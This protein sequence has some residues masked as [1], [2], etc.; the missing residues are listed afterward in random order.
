MDESTIT[1]PT[2][3]GIELQVYRF[4][5]QGRPRAVVQVQHGLGEHAGR[6]RR[7][8]GALAGAGY[9]V[10]APDARG[11]GRTAQGRYGQWG[12][13]SWLGWIDDV[14]RVRQ[15]IREDEPDL[16]LALFG[17][18]LG[19]FATQ[20]YLLDH[21]A[22]V[23]AVVLSGTAEAGSISG[24]LDSPEPADLSAFNAGFEQRTGFEWLSRDEAEVD[25]YVADE[26]CGFES[27]A[28]RGMGTLAAAADPERLRELRP[29]LP[30]LL[31]SGD[32]DPLADGGRAIEVVGER[33]REAGLTD[34]TV[35][36]YPEARHELLNE[37]NRDEV[38]AEILAFLDRTVGSG[39]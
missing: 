1:V 37:T 18:S 6:Y 25:R 12:P 5:P 22:D 26:G 34:V 35:T 8:A 11:S 30:I 27:E 21:S 3:D 31:V 16:P 20:Q 19:S 14:D 15:R 28:F 17:H 9:L 32:A 23:D 10:Y 7:F 24:M 39:R 29:D 33:Y 38:T 36:I 2:A 13:D 4:A